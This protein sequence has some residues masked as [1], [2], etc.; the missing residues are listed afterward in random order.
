MATIKK[1]M[2]VNR[3]APYGTV[4]ALESL[5]VVLIG[6]AF[7]QD[8]SLAFVDDGVYQI[9]KGQDTSGIEVKNFSPIYSALGDY[10]V[11]KLYVEKESMEERGLTLDDLMPLV[12]ED[13]DDDWAEKDSITVVS[14]AEMA[15]LLEQQDV[16]F[17]F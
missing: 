4:Y 3:K 14:R 2:Y 5:E 16:L 15:E 9:M 12:Y 11:T 10:E 13:E 7:D 17:N 1:F 8:V 6:A